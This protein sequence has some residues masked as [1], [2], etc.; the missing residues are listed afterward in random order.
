MASVSEEI[1]KAI[2]TAEVSRYRIAQD[3]GVE[4][5]TLSRFLTGERGLSMDAI[6]RLAEYFGY[7]LVKRKGK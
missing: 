4:E 7:R 1:R 5:S 3:T 6:D 2:Q